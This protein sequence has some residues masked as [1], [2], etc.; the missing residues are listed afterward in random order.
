[1]ARERDGAARRPLADAFD[2]ADQ[3]AM[4]AIGAKLEGKTG[5][6]KNPHPP[7]SLAW[8]SWICVRLGGWNCCCSKPGP[9]T[10]HRGLL[11]LRT[12]L[13]GWNLKPDVCIEKGQARP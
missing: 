12:L 5:R 3:P 9:I 11:Q 2:P 4:A 1:M 13:R 7:D 10:V 6:Q 8:A